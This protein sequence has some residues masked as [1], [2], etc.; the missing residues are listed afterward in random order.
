MKLQNIIIWFL[1]LGIIT[2][3][4]YLVYDWFCDS[5]VFYLNCAVIICCYTL[6]FYVYSG[7]FGLR[8]EF[9][10]EVPS[11]GVR[12]YIFWSYVFLALSVVVV[13]S[14]LYLSFLWQLF[15]H[16]VLLFFV[17][18]GLLLANA[19]VT[20]LETVSNQSVVK[21]ASEDELI[22]GARKALL[23]ASN[24]KS[25][26]PAFIS[27]LTKFVEKVS[28]ITP[29]NSSA[30]QLLESELLVAITSL[31]TLISSDVEKDTI[32]QSL[33]KAKTILSHRMRTY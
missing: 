23:M 3:L 20:R 24:S 2:L 33:E 17:V 9:E 32:N 16:L 30:A 19:S 6:P 8:E 7:T 26:D 27:D 10:D 1:G 29:S 15:F 25:Q 28:C 11:T 12:V 21:H 5:R 14:L 18:I 22:G 4:G 13:G 31:T